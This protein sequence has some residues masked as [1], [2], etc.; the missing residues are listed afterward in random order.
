MKI[1]YVKPSD[2]T[3][4][5]IDQEILEK[6]YPL[7]VFRVDFGSQWLL[8][9]SLVR[10]AFFMLWNRRRFNLVYTRFADYHSGMLSLLCRLLGKELLVV[11]GGYDVYHLPEFRYG[12]H[13]GKIRGWFARTTLM[14]AHYLLPNSPA[15]VHEINHYA[16]DP[17]VEA[18]I[19]RFAP[20]SKALVKVVPNGFKPGIWKAGIAGQERRTV[21]SV[22]IIDGMTTFHIKGAGYFI[23][24][25]RSMPEQKFVFVGMAKEF[26]VQH[27]LSI[28]ANLELVATLPPRDLLAIYQSARVFCIFS[29]TEGMPNA[30]CEAMLCECI[31]VGSQVSII[32]EIIG[33]SGY[34]VSRR[35]IN[36][37][38]EAVNRALQL[39]DEYGRKA[40]ERILENYSFERREK[41]LTELLGKIKS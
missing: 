27:N 24:L 13:A 23:E 26:A 30:L 37:M 4:V 33:N 29:L 16:S 40:R 39:P 31:P 3:F 28:P 21:L 18:G 9:K 12:A 19:E 14:K 15:L 10:L 6:H 2:S 36:D 7:E 11:I 17:P 32:P 8:L 38:K 5:R 25:A 35:D 34:V 41:E 22:A 20:G 1:L